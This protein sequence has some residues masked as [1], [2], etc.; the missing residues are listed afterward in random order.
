MS[1]VNRAIELCARNGVRVEGIPSFDEV[2]KSIS[3]DAP[4]GHRDPACRRRFAACWPWPRRPPPP[5]RW[6]SPAEP[7]RAEAGGARDS[8][9]APTTQA[10]PI[11]D[12]T[13]LKL[14]EKIR[15]ATLGNAYC[16]RT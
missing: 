4:R 3:E 14:Y 2:A 12:F 11:I 9:E 7:R 8:R 16:R 10:S 6:R 5:P 1:S 15:L 13:R